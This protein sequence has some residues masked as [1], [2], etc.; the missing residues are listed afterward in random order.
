[1][2]KVLKRWV[3][4]HLTDPI[5]RNH[6]R[7]SGLDDEAITKEL[8]DSLPG[9]VLFNQIDADH[10]GQIDKK[11]LKKLLMSL[12]KKKPKEPEG[13]WPNGEAPKFVPFDELVDSLDTDKDGQ[14]RSR[15]T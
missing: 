6:N 12:P 3:S 15:S 5:A 14:V 4:G 11:E 7:E 10:S 2:L 1:M 13:G 9:I 8:N